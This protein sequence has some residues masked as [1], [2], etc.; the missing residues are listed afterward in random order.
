MEKAYDVKVLLEG[1]KG[2]GLDIAED[3]AK[4]VVEEVLEW[5]V[6]SASVSKTPFDDV[7]AAVMPVAKKELLDIVDKIDGKEG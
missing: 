2:K 5:V 1:L 4:I 3:A 7:L 6:K